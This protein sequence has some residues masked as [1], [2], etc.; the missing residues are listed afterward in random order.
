MY[1]QTCNLELAQPGHLSQDTELN[2]ISMHGR[3]EEVGGREE[4]GGGRRR[5][6]GGM[7]GRKGKGRV[8]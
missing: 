4:G 1:A 8:T 2:S 3:K 6:I 7:E 5:D